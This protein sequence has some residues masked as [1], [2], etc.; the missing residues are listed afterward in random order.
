MGKKRFLLRLYAANLMIL[1]GAVLAVTWYLSLAIDELNH[2]HVALDLERNAQSVAWAMTHVPF[3]MLVEKVDPICKRLGKT[4]SSRIT[5]IVPDGRVILGAGPVFT[6]Y[7]FKQPM[8]D[9]L[10]D[11]KWRTMLRM[12]PPEKPAWL[13]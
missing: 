12:N 3:P 2:Q 5:V 6:Y 13:E 9:R 1:V 11:E 8:S 4:S 10:T 7:E